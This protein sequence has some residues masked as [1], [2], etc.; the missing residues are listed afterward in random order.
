MPQIV[1]EPRDFPSFESGGDANSL[2]ARRISFADKP[3]IFYASSGE[4]R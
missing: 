4:T 3:Q 1:Q 2:A